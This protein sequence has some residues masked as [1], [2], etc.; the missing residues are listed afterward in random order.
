[1]GAAGERLLP[2]ADRLSLIAVGRGGD[3]IRTPHRPPSAPFV[4]RRSAPSIDESV[5]HA[6]ALSRSPVLNMAG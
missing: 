1:V 2:P 6:A 5:P 3:A 4:I